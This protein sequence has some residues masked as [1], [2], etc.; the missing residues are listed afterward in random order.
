MKHRNTVRK[1]EFIGKHPEFE[2]GKE[3]S[4]VEYSNGI[5]NATGKKVPPSTIKQRLY[6]K[7]FCETRDLRTVEENIKGP[8][9]G[10]GFDGQRRAEIQSSSRLDNKQERMMAKWLKV[11]L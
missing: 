11:K 7:S 2:T 10:L 3:Y 1:V 4:Y 6:R 8:R 5:H 9:R